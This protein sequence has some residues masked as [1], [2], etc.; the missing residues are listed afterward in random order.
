[1]KE[2]PPW[3]RRNGADAPLLLVT[4]RWFVGYT[5]LAV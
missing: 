2:R 5:V 3:L 4:A 1:M